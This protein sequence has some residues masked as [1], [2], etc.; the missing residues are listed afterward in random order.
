MRPQAEM[1][2][3]HL[4]FLDNIKISLINS[5]AFLTPIARQGLFK[6][7]H[8]ARKV[9]DS[10][11]RARVDSIKTA[12]IS[13]YVFLGRILVSLVKW[14]FFQ[15]HPLIEV[16]QIVLLVNQTLTMILA[17]RVLL[18]LLVSMRHLDELDR[19][20]LVLSVLLI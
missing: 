15:R 5:A 12:R 13:R 2:L 14:K 4:V 3:V 20:R 6:A 8:Q 11:S 9:I 19:A 16:V 7:L 10:V 18:A 17:H 1:S